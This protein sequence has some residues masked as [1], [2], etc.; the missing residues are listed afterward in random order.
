MS[1]GN[2][3][4]TSAIDVIRINPSADQFMTGTD[5]TLYGVNGAD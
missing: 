2:Y 5:F 3:L 1:S 4:S